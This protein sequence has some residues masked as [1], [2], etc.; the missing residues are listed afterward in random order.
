CR[1]PAPDRRLAGLPPDPQVTPVAGTPPAF[2][3][4]PP[5]GPEIT[6]ATVAEAQKLARVEMTAADQAQLAGSWQRT[7][8]STM[9]R[10]TGPR[11]LALETTLSP[12]TLWN[13]T[14]PGVAPGPAHD[15]FVPSKAVPG[16]LPKNDADIAFA[17]VTSLS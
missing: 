10:R 4:A 13:P 9:E 7:M 11:K 15:R 6:V 8:A 5:V 17:P 3:T 14:I 2:G 16:P 12:A 1:A